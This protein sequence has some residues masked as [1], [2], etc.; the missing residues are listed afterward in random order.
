MGQFKVG[1]IVLVPFPFSDL[2]G[3]KL[4][5]ALVLARVEFDNVILCQITSRP[6]TSKVAIKI[7]QAD[8]SMGGLPLESYARIDKLFTAEPSL[9]LKPV[10]KLSPA[11]ERKILKAVRGLFSP[12]E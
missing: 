1:E 5:P 11:C 6:Y 9:I 3:Q 10:G 7:G 2:V 12:K 8:F 4:R